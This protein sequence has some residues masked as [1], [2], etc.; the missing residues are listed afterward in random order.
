MTTF[1]ISRSFYGQSI[2]GEEKSKETST[3]EPLFTA[4]WTGDPRLQEFY[5]RRNPRRN[6]RIARSS[7]RYSRSCQDTYDSG[8][9]QGKN[10]VIHKGIH[11]KRSGKVK[12]LN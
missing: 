4:F 6:P 2:R 11:G 7:S 9:T 12:F 8:M 3:E 5:R 10:L 1:K